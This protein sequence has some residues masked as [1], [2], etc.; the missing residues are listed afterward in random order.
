[1]RW[2][3][4]GLL[5]LALLGLSLAPGSVPTR[6][7]GGKALS[8]GSLETGTISDQARQV[9]YTYAGKAGEVITAHA[10]GTSAG[11]NPALALLGP[12][13]QQ[14]AT[15]DN[16]PFSLGGITDA[17]ITRRLPA[18]G[19]YGLVVSGTNGSFLLRFGVRPSGGTLLEPGVAASA[20]F[21]PGSGP[22]V[23]LFPVDPAGGTPL[24][25]TSDT[26]DFPYL[27]QVYDN[28]GQ[29]IALLSGNPLIQSVSLKLGPDEGDYELVIVPLDSTKQGS[30][31]VTAGEA[32]SFQ[33]GATATRI[34]TRV[35]TRTPT[36]TPTA[37]FTPT[38]PITLAPSRTPTR[39]P[40]L[41]LVV[42]PIRIVTVP[43][44]LI[45]T[46]I[47][48][49]PVQTA[50]PDTDN[51]LF[52]IPVPGG[53]T[54]SGDVS[55]PN[56][57]RV[58]NWRYT[59]ATTATKLTISPSC[60][61]TDVGNV[62]FIFNSSFMIL[63]GQSFTYAITSANRSGTFKVEAFAGTRTYVKYSVSFKP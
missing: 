44:I 58:D 14:I 40:T 52:G 55:Y 32:R 53:A 34:P 36:P 12:D 46:P 31:S 20:A 16:D 24:A 49:I 37:T 19:N 13:Q 8:N 15:N 28:K 9:A 2:L 48:I 25:L 38:K 17:R 4:L 57:D 11:M 50:A 3:G 33:G 29:L 10:L 1:M 30:V 47:L 21:Q 63:C 26:P 27:A 60:S 56:G 5:V 35:P 18:D 6:A 62:R 54:I 23:L 43:P 39:T 7:Q 59:A 22:A 41:G 51:I 45:I 42:P 61:G